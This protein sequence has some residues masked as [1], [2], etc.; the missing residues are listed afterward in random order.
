VIKI[1]FKQEL[2]KLY[3][4]SGKDVV[5]VSVP[6]MGFLT[7]DGEGD[8]S[9]SQDYAEAIEALFAVA[10]TL[11]V[12]VK[13]G[14]LALDYAVMP[15]EC[16]CW[17]DDMTGFASGDKSLWK[18]SAMVMQPPFITSAMVY[19]AIAEVQKK[20]HPAALVKL[21]LRSFAEGKCAQIMHIG[22]FTQEGPA[23]EK[24]HQF[25]NT[26]SELRGR[27]HEIYLSDPRKAAPANWKT[28]IRQPMQ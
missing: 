6:A 26:R 5:Q 16:L 7:V 22:P 10:N 23:V 28:I 15:L 3:L 19:G 18:W 27:H 9:T 11:K 20:K 8:P 24:L 1:D 13:K 12:T 4:A 14:A 17:A 25:I 21:R 2:E